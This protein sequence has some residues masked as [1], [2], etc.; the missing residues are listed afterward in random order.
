MRCALAGRGKRRLPALFLFFARAVCGPSGQRAAN[1]LLRFGLSARHSGGEVPDGAVQAKYI[2]IL[3]IFACLEFLSP[4]IAEQFI[5]VNSSTTFFGSK[6]KKM[7]NCTKYKIMVC[8]FSTEA[9]RDFFAR[10]TRFACGSLPP[11]GQSS[12]KERERWTEK[13]IKACSADGFAKLCAADVAVSHI[14]GEI[15]RN[16]NPLRA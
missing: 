15:G 9:V 2:R 10:K 5:Y 7:A 12:R 14:I 16:G 11:H 1:P 13:E 3:C 6:R 8:D 4:R